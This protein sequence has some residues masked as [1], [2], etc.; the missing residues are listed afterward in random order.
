ME[1]GPASPPVLAVLETAPPPDLS[2]VVVPGGPPG[3]P[4]QGSSLT[5]AIPAALAPPP[6]PGDAAPVISTIVPVSA[7]IQSGDVE[8]TVT[9]TG[10][11]EETVLVWNGVDDTHTF[12]SETEL[13]TIVKTD[14]AGA[15][16][17]CT[18]ALRNGAALSNQVNFLLTEAQE[19]PETEMSEE[20]SFPIGPFSIRAVDDHDDGIAIMLFTPEGFEEGNLDIGEGDIVRVEATGNTSINGDYEVL[21]VDGTTIV[22]DNGF[23]LDASIDNKG[24]VTVIE[25]A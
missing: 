5:G 3:G 10:F 19:Q 23:V 21:T 17:T 18:V 2:D 24:R 13:T 7:P 22:V 9:G 15:P 4:L 25:G 11:T 1:P 14:M 12:V 8:M 16:S 20:R 6:E